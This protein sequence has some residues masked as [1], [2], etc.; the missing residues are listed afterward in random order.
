MKTKFNYYGRRILKVIDN[1][2]NTTYR[3]SG[4]WVGHNYGDEFGTTRQRKNALSNGDLLIGISVNILWN[5]TGHC[6]D[7]VLAKF[8]ETLKYNELEEQ[9]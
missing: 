5:Q 2:E 9:Y 3:L 8:A 7:S 1:K 6:G 4:Q